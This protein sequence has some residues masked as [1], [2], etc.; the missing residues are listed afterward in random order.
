M[1]HRIAS[2]AYASSRSPVAW[3]TGSRRCIFE[4]RR[5]ARTCD[6]AVKTLTGQCAAP[7]TTFAAPCGG[8]NRSSPEPVPAFVAS[9]PSSLSQSRRDAFSGNTRGRR[10]CSL[11][12]D[13]VY[14]ASFLLPSSRRRN[15]R[16]KQPRP[17]VLTVRATHS[18]GSD[19]NGDRPAGARAQRP[20]PAVEWM[21]LAGCDVCIPRACLRRQRSA[22]DAPRRQRRRR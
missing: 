17:A 20:L 12:R 11:F 22:S 15:L 6:I 7:L 21:K 8:R 3:P 2:S 13:T 1:P 9:T 14:P 19:S 18:Y 16:S 10:S 5:F 4:K